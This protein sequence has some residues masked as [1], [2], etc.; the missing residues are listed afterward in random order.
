MGV[1]NMEDNVFYRNGRKYILVENKYI[2]VEGVTVIGYDEFDIPDDAPSPF[3]HGVEKFCVWIKESESVKTSRVYHAKTG[4]YTVG[5]FD[6]STIYAHDTSD[7]NT[8]PDKT[9]RAKEVS[10]PRKEKV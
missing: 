5:L 2:L 3:I 4:T 8:F 6:E 9:G 1:I 7:V 10:L